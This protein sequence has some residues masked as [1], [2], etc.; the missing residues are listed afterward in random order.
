MVLGEGGQ[1]DM[2]PLE[3]VCSKAYLQ[4]DFPVLVYFV[5]NLW[6]QIQRGP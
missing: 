4:Q 5:Q 1:Y 3:L 2:Q 6:Y